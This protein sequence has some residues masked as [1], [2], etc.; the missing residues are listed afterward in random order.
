VC[1]RRGKTD[2]SRPAQARAFQKNSIAGSNGCGKSEGLWS[3]LPGLLAAADVIPFASADTHCCIDSLVK[4]ETPLNHA[5]SRP[6]A[7]A[8]LAAAGDTAAVAELLRVVA[9]A[10]LRVVRGVMGPR[11]ADVDDALQQSLISLIHA[12]PSF[13]GECAPAGYACR[14]A[15]RAALVLRKRARRDSAERELIAAAEDAH[16]ALPPG[17]SL[18]AARRTALLRALLDELPAEQAEA[19]GLRTIL[20]W[21][22]EEIASVSGVP[23]NTVRSRLRLAKE[24]LRRKIESDPTLAEELGVRP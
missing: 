6:E 10:M 9:P 5:D 7:L 14:I 17:H 3:R 21:S 4:Q 18:E 12:L 24:A 20:G 16:D 8:R 15:F 1:R 11:S 19:L 22:R 13:R 23:L 2:H